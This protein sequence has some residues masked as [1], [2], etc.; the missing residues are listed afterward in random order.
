MF[1]EG[2]TKPRSR[3]RSKWLSMEAGEAFSGNGRDST[4]E[5]D[6]ISTVCSTRPKKTFILSLEVKSNFEFARNCYK[7]LE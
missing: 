7:I 2:E 1:A 3:M 5:I 4:T 6:A